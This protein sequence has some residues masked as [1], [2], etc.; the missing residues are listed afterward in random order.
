V[1][2]WAGAAGAATAADLLLLLLFLIPASRLLASGRRL[3]WWRRAKHCR[4]GR[5]RLLV[6]LGLHLLNLGGIV[7]HAGVD[8]PHH[9]VQVHRI[10][11][12]SRGSLLH[13]PANR[14]IN[15]RQTMHNS[16]WPR[17]RVGAWDATRQSRPT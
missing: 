10:G 4:A 1:R 9:L 15:P 3:G 11:L 8:F 7:G 13:A 14:S 2:Q 16:W 6:E 5:R 17:T 12:A